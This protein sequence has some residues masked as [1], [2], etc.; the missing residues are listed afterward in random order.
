MAMMA[1]P[2]F[3]DAVDPRW[4]TVPPE[5][6]IGD[7]ADAISRAVRAATAVAAAAG[8]GGGDVAEAFVPYCG[9]S[10]AG[11]PVE[12]RPLHLRQGALVAATEAAAAACRLPVLP[13]SADPAGEWAAAA[14]WALRVA[15]VQA[16]APPDTPRREIGPDLALEFLRD[17]VT[18]DVVRSAVEVSLGDDLEGGG[19]GGREARGSRHSSGAA[20][21]PTG[22]GRRP[23]YASCGGGG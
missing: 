10:G 17:G 4:Q 20:V 15:P 11:I 13:L 21:G 9:I 5:R 16:V 23:R 12:L 7:T 3:P 2:A 19:R 8:T 1:S 18:V 6:N 14:A 22:W